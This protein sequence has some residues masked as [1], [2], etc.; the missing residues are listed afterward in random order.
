MAKLKKVL[1]VDSFRNK[2]EK[3]LFNFQLANANVNKHI[4]DTFRNL[5]ITY[6]QYLALKI[7]SEAEGPVNN[8]YI[9]K[10]II[11]NDSDVSRLVNRLIQLGFL[12]KQA[13]EDDKRHSEISITESGLEQVA[14]VKKSMHS[15]DEVFYNLSAKEVK[16]L[17]LLLDKIR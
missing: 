7:V 9:K 5:E 8:A 16:Q 1:R 4:R 15:V 12:S 10:R 11:D 6:T 2:W 14:R 17:N 13:R 3:V